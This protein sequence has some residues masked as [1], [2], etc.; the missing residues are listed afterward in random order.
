LVKS[1]GTEETDHAIHRA[2]LTGIVAPL[3][4]LHSRGYAEEKCEMATCRAAHRADSLGVDC[5]LRRVRAHPAYRGFAVVNRGRKLIRRR[6]SIRD[7][8]RHVT[9]LRQREAQLVVSLSRACP[10]ATAVY[11]D[12]RRKWTVASLRAR[13]IESE[14]LVVRICEL[15][16]TLERDVLRDQEFGG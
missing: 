5:V 2:G 1:L 8:R 14:M 12:D 13:Q 7:R 16:A 15:Q 4:L 6:Q 10:K 9:A 3:E 11:A